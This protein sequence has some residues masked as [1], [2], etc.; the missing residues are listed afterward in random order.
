MP[1]TNYGHTIDYI[2]NSLDLF[3]LTESEARQL[4]YMGVGYIALLKA[5]IDNPDISIETELLDSN[6]DIADY[7]GYCPEYKKLELYQ[8]S[9]NVYEG[10]GYY[11]FRFYNEYGKECRLKLKLREL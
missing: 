7:V 5:T 11:I 1:I 2:A 9:L 3:G 10:Y 8:T 4:A 6:R